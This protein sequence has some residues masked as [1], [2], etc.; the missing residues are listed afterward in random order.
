MNLKTAEKQ[1]VIVINTCVRPTMPAIGDDDEDTV[2]TN[3]V[4]PGN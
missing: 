3:Q 2:A 4:H 1:C